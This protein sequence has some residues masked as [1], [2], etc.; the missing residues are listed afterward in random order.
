MSS[1]TLP[2]PSTPS[3]TLS[4]SLSSTLLSSTPQAVAR[5]TGLLYLAL[6]VSGMVGFL[7]FRSGLVVDQDAAA[8]FARMA[9]APQ[10]ARWLVV[11][12]LALATTQAWAAVWFFRFFRRVNALDAGVMV[13]A[14]G[15]ANAIMLL[16]SAA[17]LGSAARM[18]HL[19]SLAVG[20]DVAHAVYMLVQLSTDIWGVAAV[21]FGLWLIPMGHAVVVRRLMPKALGVVLMVGGVGYT[22]GA[23]V[24]YAFAVPPQ[25]VVDMLLFPATVGEFWMIGYL[26]VFGVR[27]EHR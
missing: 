18:V 23:F 2:P 5:Q 6:A 3:S 22:A 1:T 9:A 4:S 11:A 14:F 26:L 8:T 24:T 19:P 15:V 16:G 10:D 21:F 12:E 7:G 17:C 20:G 25:G 27:S 13:G